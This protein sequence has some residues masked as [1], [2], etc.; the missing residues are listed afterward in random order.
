MTT[1][2]LA[3]LIGRSAVAAGAARRTI[4]LMG[5]SVLAGGLVLAGCGPAMTRREVAR[6]DLLKLRV[7][8]DDQASMDG[9]KNSPK[10]A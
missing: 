5:M 3:V 8:G 10:I 2:G 4:S 6:P 7:K 9:E 1:K